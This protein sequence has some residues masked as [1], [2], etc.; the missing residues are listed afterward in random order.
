[1]SNEDKVEVIRKYLDDYPRSL[2]YRL[3]LDTDPNA[4]EKLWV[5]FNGSECDEINRYIG[6]DNVIRLQFGYTHCPED[7]EGN[8]YENESLVDYINEYEIPAL[9]EKFDYENVNR[10][11]KNNAHDIVE[12]DDNYIIRYL[13]SSNV[14]SSG[15][16]GGRSRIKYMEPEPKTNTKEETATKDKAV[17]RGNVGNSL[18]K[19]NVKDKGFSR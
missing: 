10:E 3:W 9:E 15:H 6:N 7:A 12:A 8:K 14:Y 4:D 13:A 11:Y 17:F 5:T 1:M 19:D 18:K 16:D 2:Y